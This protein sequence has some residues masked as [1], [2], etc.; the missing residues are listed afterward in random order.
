[1]AAFIEKLG[2]II[3]I[4]MEFKG[5]LMAVLRKGW[6]VIKG[7]LAD[8]IGFLGNLIAAIKQ[9]VSQFV[10][11]IWTH[12][13]AGFMKWLFGA[14]GEAGI[15]IPPGLPS[16]PSILKL[17]LGVLGLTYERMR[18]K[19]VK[20]IGPSAVAVIEKAVE[21]VKALI[22]G[23]PAALWE[24]VK[25]DLSTLKGM[26][27]DA[28]QDWII[29]TIIKQATTKLLSMFN[30]AGAIVQACIMIYSTVMFLIERA[31]QIMA[32]VEAVINS[33]S[34]IA[35]GAIGGAAEWIERSLANAIPLVIGFLAALIGL[36]GI[37]KKIKETI[38]KVQGVVDKAIDKAIGKIIEMVKKMAKALGGM[39]GGKDARTEEE[40]K[41]DLDKA[42]K[43]LQPQ[44]KPLLDKG[45]PRPLFLAKLMIWK[46]QYKLTSLGIEGGKV[47]A[48]INPSA[49]MYTVEEVEIGKMLEPILVAAEAQYLQERTGPGTASAPN[50]AQARADV[51]AGQPISQKM[52]PDE[53]IAVQRELASGTLKPAPLGKNKAGT[54]SSD[55]T[56][57]ATQGVRMQMRERGSVTPGQFE[58]GQGFFV[59]EGGKYYPKKEFYDETPLSPSKKDP[60][61]TYLPQPI[62]RQM[63]LGI[64]NQPTDPK[65]AAELEKKVAANVFLRDVVEPGR[66]PTVMAANRVATGLVGAGLASEQEMTTGKMAGGT[67]H[68]SAAAAQ[69]DFFGKAKPVGAS[70]KAISAKGLD[71][72]TKVRQG[73]LGVVFLRLRDALN[74]GSKKGVKEAGGKPMANL[75]TAFK[76]WL[77]SALPPKGAPPKPPEEMARLADRLKQRLVEF[78]HSQQQ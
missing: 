48:T 4:I 15:E 21:Y 32:F 72:A 13:K 45:L 14:L 46:R 23:G 56:T 11:N 26:V 24:K 35:S 43:A 33:V 29:T 16:L 22:T 68:N 18:A 19:A 20:L 65:L 41:K 28:I 12:L 57:E 53:M 39:L 60:T 1:M 61:K 74:A 40:K 37:S 77:A 42:V 25:E 70:G 64:A 58:S 36:G 3:K 76:S 73:S 2:E 51:Q 71:E 75:A 10:A 62:N 44:I 54:P 63:G 67:T 34:A 30:P 8:P 59:P 50:M 17:V 27:I 6:D 49:D 47:R 78:L 9:G 38:Q 66:I 5:K 31:A 7:I 55:L 69:R 52:S